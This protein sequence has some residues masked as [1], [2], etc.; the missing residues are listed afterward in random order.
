MLL[1]TLET[2]CDDDAYAFS[3]SEI[4]VYEA[5]VNV[6]IIKKCAVYCRFPFL[7]RIVAVLLET[8]FWEKWS[9]NTHDSGKKVVK[10]VNNYKE[11]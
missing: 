6:S 2:S 3:T 9:M 8:F 10:K 4:D 11:E 1:I 7:P 5:L